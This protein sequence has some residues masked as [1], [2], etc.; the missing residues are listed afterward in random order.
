MN[1]RECYYPVIGYLLLFISVW[2]FSWVLDIVTTFMGV[3]LG[4]ASLVSSEG[5]R[6]FMRNA[7]P[8]LNNVAWGE[9]MLLISALG[10]LQGSGLTRLFV[11]LIRVQRLTKMERRSMIFAL[12]AILMYL[13]VLYITT[14]SQW[15][16]LSGVTGTLENSSF[17][18]GL[19]LLLFFGV[20]ILALVYGFMYGNYR[21][22]IDIVSSIGNTCAMFVPALMALIPA[23]GVIASIAYL[24]VLDIW[25]LTECEGKIITIVFYSIPF[26]HIMFRKNNLFAENL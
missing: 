12:L 1:K 11:H 22:V 15:N 6:W 21:S 9:I 4:V 20:L 23:S 18:S 10:L 26:L 25:G 2:L 17:V 3:D 7:L 13:A 16:V 19:P 8:T 5:M 14:L 24:G